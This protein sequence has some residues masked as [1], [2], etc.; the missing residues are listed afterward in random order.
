M[1]A[2]TNHSKLSGLRQQKLS[3]PRFRG[4]EVGR[5]GVSRAHSRQ[6]LGGRVQRGVVQLPAAASPWFMASS[7]QCP[8]LWSLSSFCVDCLCLSVIRSLVTF[9]TYVD[10]PDQSL[11]V[12]K[13]K[14]KIATHKLR[15]GRFHM[16]LLK[17]KRE[18]DV[19]SALTKGGGRFRH[20]VSW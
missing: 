11:R 12:V 6:M 9:T 13:E 18:M 16:R 4:P 10:K 2:I 20:G 5:E 8:P 1:A 19:S 15:Q 14:K 17:R 3:A 7:L